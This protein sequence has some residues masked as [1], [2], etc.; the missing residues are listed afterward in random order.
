MIYMQFF[1]LRKTIEI[2]QGERVNRMPYC[3]LLLN[4]ELNL[5]FI[6]FD[7]QYI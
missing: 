4:M 7:F 2:V 5:L 6:C 3:L 1:W